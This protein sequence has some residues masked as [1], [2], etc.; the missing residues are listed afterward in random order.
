MKP[1]RVIMCLFL[2]ITSAGLIPGATSASPSKRIRPVADGKET[3]QKVLG[4]HH[5]NMTRTLS[6]PGPQ[7]RKRLPG[8][9]L[10]PTATKPFLYVSWF[11][12]EKVLQ[13]QEAVAYH[14]GL[15]MSRTVQQG[16]IM[17]AG[18]EARMPRD[19]AWF[20][21]L[22]NLPAMPAGL[23]RPDAVP[24]TALLIASQFTHRRW[25]TR[26]YDLRH[27][28]AGCRPL[29]NALTELGDFEFVLPPHAYGKRSVE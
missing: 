6:F 3:Y 20:H 8:E 26:Y 29:F 19:Q 22:E 11:L 28:P 4:F 7:P 13:G 10:M 24:H 2:L 23:S 21:A 5:G 12:N 27:L 14:T 17:G 15:L 25:R 1:S 9:H 16:D 18:G